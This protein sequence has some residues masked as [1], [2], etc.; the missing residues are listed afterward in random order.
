[1]PKDGRTKGNNALLLNGRLMGR[2]RYIRLRE[3]EA[4]GSL[5]MGDSP[6]CPQC[7]RRYC[8]H[9]HDYV[10]RPWRE[11]TKPLV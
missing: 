4:A 6:Q 7:G 8:R 9:Y 11:K 1:M 2:K 10:Y 3:S 5:N